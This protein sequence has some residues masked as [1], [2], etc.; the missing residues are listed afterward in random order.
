MNDIHDRLRRLLFL[1][2]YV[3]R[4]PGITLEALAEAL[5]VEKEGLLHELEL[6]AMVGRPP[7]QPDDYIDVYVENGRVYV[8]LDQ[9]LSAPPRLTAGEAAA[10]FAAASLLEPAAGDALGAALAKL[11]AVLPPAAKE[12]AREMTRRIHAGAEGPAELVPLREAVTD[13]REITFDYFAHGRGATEARRVQ[14]LEL[15]NHRGQW[16]LAGFDRGRGEE[17]LFR[18]D[19]LQNLVLTDARFEPPSTRTANSRVPS[20]SGGEVRVR[21]TR[22]AAPYVR[23]RFGEHARLL[24]D[25][26]VEVTVTGASERWLV[27]WVLSFGGDAEVLEPAWAREAVARAA[28]TALSSTE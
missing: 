26:Q 14:P 16:Y 5:G 8:E 3:R 11:E 15:L 13:R 10:L 1:V 12:R 18:L 25:G 17:R 19:R 24:S 4:H 23:E 2:P 27:G 22:A 28:Q 20:P 7:F 6:L 9:R 21:F